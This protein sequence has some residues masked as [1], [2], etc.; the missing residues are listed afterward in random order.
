MKLFWIQQNHYFELIFLLQSI[1]QDFLRQ[2]L[3]IISTMFVTKNSSLLLLIVYWDF[4]Y[5]M[6]TW[7]KMIKSFN[8]CFFQNRLL[9]SQ[10]F[11]CWNNMNFM[12]FEYDFVCCIDSSRRRNVNDTIYFDWFFVNFVKCEFFIVLILNDIVFMQFR[13]RSKSFNSN[14]CLF[15]LKS[16]CD[17]FLKMLWYFDF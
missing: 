10:H 5:A 4:H 12:K 15:L 7:S 2:F 1:I 3:M 8:C 16:T 9:Q 14:R 6:W 11:F 17:L 13:N